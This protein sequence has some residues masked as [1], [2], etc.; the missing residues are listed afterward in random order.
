VTIG[1]VPCNVTGVSSFSLQCIPGGMGSRIYAE[2]WYLTNT[3]FFP[4]V[5]T[6]TNPGE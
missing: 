6:Y 1:G 4:D 2:Y 5:F 3:Y